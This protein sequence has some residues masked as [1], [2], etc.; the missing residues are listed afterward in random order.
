[1]IATTSVYDDTVNL[2]KGL[3]ANQLMAVHSVIVEL[4]NKNKGWISPLGITSEEQLW[5]HVDHSLEQAK[6]G[7]GRDSDLVANDLLQ[8]FM[9]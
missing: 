1:M 4:A 7:E 5:G 3:D 9:A 8:E 6:A 2:L